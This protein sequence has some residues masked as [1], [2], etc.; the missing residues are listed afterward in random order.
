MSL[1]NKS[2]PSNLQTHSKCSSDKRSN[3]ESRNK[4]PE[5]RVVMKYK[6][7]HP[8]VDATCVMQHGLPPINGVQPVIGNY[9]ITDPF[10]DKKLI[11]TD[12]LLGTLLPMDRPLQ[13]MKLRQIF[14][15][16]QRIIDSGTMIDD[17]AENAETLLYEAIDKAH[18]I[19]RTLAE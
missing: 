17:R 19:I 15:L 6:Y 10:G 18:E 7:K 8:V 5:N 9:V 16:A 2:K 4:K 11:T 1:T 12:Q 14:L 3:H 13:D